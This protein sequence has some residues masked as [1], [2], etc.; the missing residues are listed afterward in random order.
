MEATKQLTKRELEVVRLISD[1]YTDLEIADLLVISHATASTHR[2]NILRKLE[3]KNT[4][5]LIRYAIKHKL[6]Q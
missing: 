6:V 1:G 5:L 2:K 3:L 4:A